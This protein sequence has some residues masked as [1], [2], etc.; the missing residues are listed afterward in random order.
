MIKASLAWF[1]KGVTSESLTKQAADVKQLK[2]CC[3]RFLQKIGTGTFSRCV[4][5][6]SFSRLWKKCLSHF[7]LLRVIIN[8]L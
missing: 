7:L 5:M 4:M 6:K 1:E 3:P 2:D 8:P